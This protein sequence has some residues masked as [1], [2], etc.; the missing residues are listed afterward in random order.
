MREWRAVAWLALVLLVGACSRKGPEPVVV[1][2][3]VPVQETPPSPPPL[4]ASPPPLLPGFENYI[5]FEPLDVRA[6]AQRWY[7]QTG[8]QFDNTQLRLYQQPVYCENGELKFPSSDHGFYWF[9]GPLARAGSSATVDLAYVDCDGCT[10]P[11]PRTERFASS[12]LSVAF[13]DANTL[14]L[15]GIRFD[16]RRSWHDKACPDPT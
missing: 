6:H 12:H 5:G 1:V 11:G 10:A 2:P 15:G 8:V 4:P 16:R 7:L 9:A 3:D 14:E 13:P